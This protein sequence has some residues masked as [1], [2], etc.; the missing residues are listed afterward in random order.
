MLKINNTIIR[1]FREVNNNINIVHLLLKERNQLI[2]SIKTIK[3][4][5]IIN[6]LNKLIILL[7][8]LQNLIKKINNKVL[9]LI[10]INK[11]N[12]NSIKTK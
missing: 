12:K 2:N 9:I 11:S 10:K 3:K 7:G 6:F 4:I 8:F 1:V 5:L